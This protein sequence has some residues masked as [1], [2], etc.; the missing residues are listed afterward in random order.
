MCHSPVPHLCARRAREPGPRRRR[1][2]GGQ[3]AGGVSLLR[4]VWVSRE[5]RH[6]RR[7]DTEK[8]ER[9]LQENRDVEPKD[10]LW[11]MV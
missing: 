8:G 4:K 3:Q 2:P 1:Q 5:P 10:P 6:L 7:R 9:A 11:C